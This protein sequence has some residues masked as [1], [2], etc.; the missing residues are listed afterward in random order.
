MNNIVHNCF[1]LEL[2]LFPRF[3]S[4]LWASL[5]QKDIDCYENKFFKKLTE[6]IS[7]IGNK[8]QARSNTLSIRTHANI[9]VSY[10][11]KVHRYTY[12]YAEPG[13]VTRQVLPT[14]GATKKNLHPVLLRFSVAYRALLKLI[15]TH[16]QNN[17]VTRKVSPTKRSKL[18]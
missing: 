2:F 13:E 17:S 4:F 11:Y 14:T 15:L 8:L 16:E 1:L 9:R 10:T 12:L 6:I 7:S 3:V 18:R 5:H